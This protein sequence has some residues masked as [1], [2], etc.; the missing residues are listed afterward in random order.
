MSHKY[1]FKYIVVG[2]CSVGK[3]SIIKRFAGHS[4]EE[5][6][7]ATLGIDMANQ[8]LDINGEKINVIIWD[9]AGSEAF[10]SLT[11][12]YYRAVAGI[13]LVYDITDESTFQQLEYWVDECKKHANSKASILL[14]GNKADMWNKRKVSKEEAQA[15]ADKHKMKFI[16]T[17]AKTADNIM[18][19]FLMMGQE[20]Y[21]KIK[22]GQIDVHDPESGARLSE[23]YLKN[24]PTTVDPSSVKDGGAKKPCQC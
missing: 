4:F 9:T 14:I 8:V 21:K 19:A 22:D 13:L 6:H 10:R 18:E 20:I 12:S 15:F 7:I 5:K 23:K 16:E 3:T 1:I 24:D 2:E 17:S 11:R